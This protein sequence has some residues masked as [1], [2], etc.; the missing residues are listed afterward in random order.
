[1]RV[2]A[3][4]PKFRDDMIFMVLQAK[5]ALGCVPHL[6][7]DLLDVPGHYRLDQG[8]AFFLALDDHDRVIGCIGVLVT[9]RSAR[10]HRLYVKASLKRKGIGTA[11]LLRA[12]EFARDQGAGETVVHMGDPSFYWESI[13]F[14]INHGYSETSPR[15]MKKRLADE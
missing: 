8:G 11:L 5:D 13:P 4:D 6:N 1:M 14:Y 3:F 12:Q 2:I 10:L 15:W 7:E 9:D